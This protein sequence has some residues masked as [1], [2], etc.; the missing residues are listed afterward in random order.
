[1]LLYYHWHRGIC[2][3]WVLLI[4]LSLCKSISLIIHTTMS[5]ATKQYT[6]KAET[7]SSPLRAT[8]YATYIHRS[9]LFTK[10]SRRISELHTFKLIQIHS[11]RARVALSSYRQTRYVKQ[12]SP[13]K[14]T[15]SNYSAEYSYKKLP[16]ARRE[17]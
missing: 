4:L 9:L 10:Q 2:T 11:V 7:N 14:D 6:R 5:V 8:L 17:S 13:K 15:C 16:R 12:F 1:M 3:V